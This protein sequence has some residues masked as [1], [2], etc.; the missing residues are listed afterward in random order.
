M[1]DRIAEIKARCEAATP[2]PWY[3]GND[4]LVMKTESHA[5]VCDT[6]ARSDAAFIAHARDDIPDL[7]AELERV[8]AERDAAVGDLST[9]DI[10]GFCAKL[11]HFGGECMGIAMTAVYPDY[12]CV[13]EW[14]GAQKEAEPC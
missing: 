8:T 5:V 2:G 4:T 1:S 6:R 9:T 11:D 7:L 3:K 12:K 10:C 13:W 14:R